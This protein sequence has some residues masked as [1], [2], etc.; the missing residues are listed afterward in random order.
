[1]LGVMS[2]SPAKKF[3]GRIIKLASHHRD[4]LV[5]SVQRIPTHGSFCTPIPAPLCVLRHSLELGHG[6]ND[7]FQPA[8]LLLRSRTLER[9]EPVK[10]G[11]IPQ[12][13]GA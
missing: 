7:G 12:S 9:L 1:M 3:V 2:G 8:A 5:P 10:Q 13:F 6:T 4:A 11:L